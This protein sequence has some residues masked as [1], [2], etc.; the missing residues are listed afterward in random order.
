MSSYHLDKVWG[1]TFKYQKVQGFC[2]LDLWQVALK[3]NSDHLNPNMNLILVIIRTRF[4]LPTYRW[5]D[6]QTDQLTW[7][8]QYTWKFHEL[9]FYYT[10]PCFEG[11]LRKGLLRTLWRKEKGL[12]VTI[13]SFFHT[14]FYIFK[15]NSKPFIHIYF[16]LV[17]ASFLDKANLLYDKSL[18]DNRDEM[19]KLLELFLCWEMG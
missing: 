9:T 12:E 2:N 15:S 18:N 6:G 1:F 7:A 17:H 11:L 14:I 3:I 19:Q 4:G 8:K 16:L 10:L 5:M 13:F